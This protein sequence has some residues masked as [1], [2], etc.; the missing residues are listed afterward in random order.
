[1]AASTG[2]GLSCQWVLQGCV[3]PA[4]ITFSMCAPPAL[5]SRWPCW[6]PAQL[7]APL[8]PAAAQAL[9]MESSV[10]LRLCQRAV[11]DDA[12][13]ACLVL[14]WA[15]AAYAG[16]AFTQRSHWL[17]L[18]P[19]R[20]AAGAA[21]AAYVA[22][23]FVGDPALVV[24]ALVAGGVCGPVIW[25]DVWRVVRRFAPV[26]P[27]TLQPC[28]KTWAEH[29]LAA[30]EPASSAWAP[31][32][33]LA[34]LRAACASVAEPA[35]HR[36]LLWRAA[37]GPYRLSHDELTMSALVAFYG[38]CGCAGCGGLPPNRTGSSSGCRSTAEPPVH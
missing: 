24:A 11:P 29:G 9:A 10:C 34:A 1:M 20:A 28:V 5:T 18:G 19:I 8:A 33:C 12:C 25:P 30:G 26:L 35:R 13:S 21:A 17:V 23:L 14:R 27:S 4:G 16:M 7:P 2:N 37:D 36:S 38:R 15:G 22:A 6:V 32:S 31:P 3:K